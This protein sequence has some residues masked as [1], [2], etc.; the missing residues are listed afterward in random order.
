VGLLSN[1]VG[2]FS[3][4][5]SQKYAHS[6]FV[7]FRETVLI[8]QFFPRPPNC[9]S[10]TSPNFP[11]IWYCGRKVLYQNV[12]QIFWLVSTEINITPYFLDHKGAKSINFCEFSSLFADVKKAKIMLLEIFGRVSCIAPRHIIDCRSATSNL[13]PYLS[14]DLWFS[15]FVSPSSSLSFSSLLC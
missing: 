10:K 5:C 2:L 4:E 14:S 8:W 12:L 1:R 7:Y 13:P 15:S 6:P 3:R 9:Q 11:A